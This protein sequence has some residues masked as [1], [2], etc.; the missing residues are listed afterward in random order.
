MSQILEAVFDGVVLRPDEPLELKANTR[1]R[2]V[3]EE[4][5]VPENPAQRSF[6][7]T[8]RALRLEG[9]RDW[10]ENLDAYLSGEAKID[11]E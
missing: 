2:L 10:S 1:V 9:P 3:V 6:L 4:V 7:N 11:G 5:V 8:A